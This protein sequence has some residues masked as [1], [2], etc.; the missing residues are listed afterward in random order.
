[1]ITSDWPV[2]KDYFCLGTVHVP[3]TVEGIC[4]GVRRAQAEHDALQRDILRLQDLLENEWK[5]KLE[6][7]QDLL[8][9]E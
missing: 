8:R 4:R 1:M 9:R 7:L 5:Q 2:L 6:Q 3:N